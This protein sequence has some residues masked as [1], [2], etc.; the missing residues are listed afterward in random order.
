MHKC[1][2]CSISILKSH[3]KII[4]YVSIPNLCEPLSNRIISS[5]N[6]SLRIT[7]ERS[8][9][10]LFESSQCEVI[11]G[12]KS[13]ATLPWWGQRKIMAKTLKMSRDQI[14]SSHKTKILKNKTDYVWNG[15]LW[16]HKKNLQPIF[17]RIL[18]LQQIYIHLSIWNIIFI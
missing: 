12:C 10:I 9:K 14:Y 7:C 3:S 11:Y 16:K 4:K 8:Q 5:K 6:Y 13:K 17:V 18:T 15:K 2:C 1:I